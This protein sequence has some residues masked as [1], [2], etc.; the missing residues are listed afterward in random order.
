M[1]KISVIMP[2]LNMRQYV[3]ES[4]QSVLSQTMKDIEV[5]FVDAGSTDGTLD[6]ARQYEEND[7]RFHIVYSDQKSYGYQVNLGIRNA[8]GDYIAIVDTDDFI[9][10]DMYE[11]LFCVAESNHADYVKGGAEYFW[12]IENGQRIF[13]ETL[14]FTRE[15]YKRGVIEVCPC[16]SPYLTTKDFFLWE[17]IYRRKLWEQISLHET[18]GARYQDTGGLLN[19]VYLAKKAVFIP[20]AFYKY[21]QDNIKA[22][23]YDRKGFGYTIH[24]YDYWLFEQGWAHKTREWVQALYAKWCVQ[25][26]AKMHTMSITGQFWDESEDDMNKIAE[27]FREAQAKGF[28]ERNMLPQWVKKDIEIFLRSPRELFDMLVYY[29]KEDRANSES[30]IEELKNKEQ[31]VIYGAGKNGRILCLMLQNN[32]IPA[33]SILFCDSN[34]GDGKNEL[35]GVKIC[36][37]EYAMINYADAVYVVS[38]P[39]Y[40]DGMR[41]RLA[42]FGIAKNNIMSLNGNLR[43]EFVTC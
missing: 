37:P 24:E 14:Q 4:I 12:E 28:L 32:G 7:Y 41:Q 42:D 40:G 1:P 25:I 13:V 6:I 11:T 16:R 3:E 21:R 29:V 9:Q 10:E 23:G 39:K 5:L 43:T 2:C 15:E 34:N 36:S 26:I 8:K 27:R 38:S 17:G 19:T 31:I 22:S 33:D 35:F 20:K 18:P 30:L